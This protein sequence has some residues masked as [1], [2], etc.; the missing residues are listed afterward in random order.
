MSLAS[1]GLV[2]A[3]LLAVVLAVLGVVW[4][5]HMRGKIHK[6]TTPEILPE[7]TLAA[8]PGGQDV[9]RMIRSEHAE[10]MAPQFSSA[11]LLPGAGMAVLQAN[12]NVPGRGQIPVLVGTDEASLP[13]QIDPLTFAPRP[14][15]QDSPISV[16]VQ[17]P[18]GPNW[19]TATE[20][21]K[22][23][24]AQTATSDFLPDGST[25]TATFA[26]APP[27][28]LDGH[29][30]APSGIETKIVTTITGRGLDLNISATNR[31]DTPRAV[32]IEWQANFAA[33]QSGLSG[34]NV[35]APETV[36]PSATAASRALPLGEADLHA[37]F[38][39]LKYSYLSQG[40]EMQLRNQADGYTL[41]LTAMTPSIRSM[42]MDAAKDGK[43]VAIVFSTTGSGSAEQSRTVVA[44][45]ETLQWRVRVDAPSDAGYRAP[46]Q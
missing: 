39:G 21:V 25:S 11:L 22:N 24:P 28:G 44:P 8:R 35:L 1:S 23:R 46:T 16:R 32:V 27:A 38:T 12:L 18:N 10:G 29:V 9:V 37:V 26:A 31:N 7:T 34:M 33:P 45:H 17:V 5:A 41:R 3:L 15:L 19:G 40:P 6:M 20:L 43:S 42:R 2:T 30:P 36:L 14:G 13:G 4:K